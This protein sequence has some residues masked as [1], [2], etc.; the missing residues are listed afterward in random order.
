MGYL[1]SRCA[2]FLF[3]FYFLS[4]LYILDIYFLFDVKLVKTLFSLCSLLFGPKDVVLYCTED[5]RYYE[6]L[7]LRACAIS[8]LSRSLEFKAIPHILLYHTHCIWFYVEVFDTLGVK[9]CIKC[10]YG[11]MCTLHK[12]IQL[13]ITIC[14]RC[15]PFSSVDIWLLLLKIRCLYLC[16]LM[17]GF[18]IQFNSIQFNSIQF[19]SIQ[20]INASLFMPKQYHFYYY[21]CVVQSEIRD[22]YTSSTSFIFQ[23]SFNYPVL[24]VCVS[25]RSYKLSSHG[26]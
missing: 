22:G 26:L 24:H 4:S 11:S 20:L 5:F 8:V 25:I 10:K 13:S 17:S 3:L 16:G 21:G 19:N 9:L 2:G 1:F 14:W 7:V 6:L 18:S 12:V 15:C 23:D